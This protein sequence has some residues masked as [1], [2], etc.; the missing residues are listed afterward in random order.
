MYILTR[1][2][3]FPL[4]PRVT[5]LKFAQFGPS[6]AFSGL[7]KKREPKKS[8][9]PILYYGVLKNGINITHT[10]HVCYGIFT[11]IYYKSQLSVG[12]YTIH[13]CYG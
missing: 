3:A 11:Y 13:G 10:I 6:Q 12:K 1:A 7:R 8:L 9:V 5:M 2:P 4:E